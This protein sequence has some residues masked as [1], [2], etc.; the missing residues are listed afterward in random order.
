MVGKE[1]S[2]P[3]VS[4]M[5]TDSFI[6]IMQMTHSECECVE[7]GEQPTGRM[8]ACHLPEFTLFRVVPVTASFWPL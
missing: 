2:H 7:L 6:G 8:F 5:T 1:L 3:E 4:E